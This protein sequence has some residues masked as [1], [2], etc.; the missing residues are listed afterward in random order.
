MTSS[1]DDRPSRDPS[2]VGRRRPIMS[3]RNRQVPIR[4]LI[5]NMF[6]VLGLVAGL[7]AIRLAIEG[8]HME[9]MLLIVA[10]AIIDGIDGRLARMLKVQSR[11][12]AEL[13]SLADFVDFG[14]AP[15]IILFTWALAGQPRL[16][17]IAVMVF[18]V[19]C[20]LRLARFNAALDVEKPRWQSNYFTGVP[21]PA[22]AMIVM[23]PLYV[24]GI[25]LTGFDIKSWPYLIMLYTLA[26]AFLLVSTIP[27][28]SGKL[29][30][31]KIS[32][33]FVPL[34]FMGVAAVAA[35]LFTYPYITLSV[36]V[37]IY[38]GMI[39]VSMRRYRW[40]KDQEIAE[41]S[42]RQQAAELAKVPVAIDAA[43]VVPPGTPDTRH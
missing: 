22:G 43:V 37:L 20:A 7:T 31:E 28:F 17:W 30:G 29:A 12:G 38:L 33:E 40:H 23:L 21:A 36:L 14:V 11:F 2:R 1:N 39:G 27:T 24:D 18:T 34:I 41:A 42:A 9:A 4:A 19:A 8:R 6:T 25:G 10:A 35:F 13:D 5:P 16:G 26:M 32:R 15:A 3:F